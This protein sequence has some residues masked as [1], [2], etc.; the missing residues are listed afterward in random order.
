VASTK[1]PDG[2]TKR[3]TAPRAS[4]DTKPLTRDDKRELKGKFTALR[5]DLDAALQL[6]P[7]GKI[8]TGTLRTLQGVRQ[9]LRAL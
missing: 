8:R 2:A 1:K 5:G 9:T 3:E 7:K 4:E 6:L